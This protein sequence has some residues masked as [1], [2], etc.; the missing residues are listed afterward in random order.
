[1]VMLCIVLGAALAFWED[2]SLTLLPPWVWILAALWLTASV[3]LFA[4]PKSVFK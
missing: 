4:A 2:G 1:M 3:F